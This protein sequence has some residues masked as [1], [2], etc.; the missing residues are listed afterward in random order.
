[1]QPEGLRR[2]STTRWSLVLAAGAGE[3][4]AA[5]AAL[6][7]LC[8]LYWY[9]VYAFVRRGGKAHDDALDL[10]QEFFARLIERGDVAAADP[11]RGRFRSW[12]LGALKH[13]LANAWDRAT[14]Q[15]RDVRKLSSLD[16]GDAETRYLREPAHTVDPERLYD[17][18]FALALL[19]RTLVRLR[20]ECAARG[21]A[22][23]FEKVKGF[24]VG[25]EDEHP[26]Y[27]ELADSL[28]M[29]SGN[30]K[31]SIH[32]LR[33]RYADLLRAEIAD[34]VGSRD[35]VEG[36]IDFLLAALAVPEA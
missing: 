2:F 12:L 6:A 36:E 22:A 15:K 5:R 16:A 21:K 20:D 9:P 23:L 28:G 33:R 19:D 31:V 8:R 10:T 3:G 7:E 18:H 14:A 24:L 26:A 27:V 13:F 25:A 32:R 1:M 11:Q 4:E 35:D 17:R 30:L 29:T 34:T